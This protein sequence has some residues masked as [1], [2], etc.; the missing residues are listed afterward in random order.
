MQNEFNIFMNSTFPSVSKESE[1]W[2]DLELIWHSSA[3]TACNLATKGGLDSIRMT[4]KESYDYCDNAIKRLVEELNEQKE[5]DDPFKRDSAFEG[6]MIFH[7]PDNTY[8]I[9]NLWMFISE[10][11]KGEGI[12]AATTE[13][14]LLMPLI[15]ADEANIEKIKELALGATK[16]TKKS[17]KLIKFSQREDI[18]IVP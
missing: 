13:G 15:T 12:I 8:E 11:S 10:D 6:D 2:R 14:G 5:G 7:D 16:A 4:F 17:I 18:G 1:Q 3:V 9:K